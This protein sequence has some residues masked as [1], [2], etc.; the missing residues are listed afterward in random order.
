[1]KERRSHVVFILSREDCSRQFHSEKKTD[2]I[3]IKGLIGGNMIDFFTLRMT[4]VMAG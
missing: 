3:G 4:R 1:M 2:I